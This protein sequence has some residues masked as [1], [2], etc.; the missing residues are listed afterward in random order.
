MVKEELQNVWVYSQPCHLFIFL[1]VYMPSHLIR[2][3][4]ERK[5]TGNLASNC[6]WMA[7]KNRANQSLMVYSKY[8]LISYNLL[9][10]F[11]LNEQYILL[12][13]IDYCSIL[14]VFI[15]YTTAIFWQNRTSS[16]ISTKYN[17]VLKN[18]M[19]IGKNIIV[20]VANAW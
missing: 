2:M 3:S 14:V 10:M 16:E 6:S 17:F 7:N 8:H 19:R 9:F 18:G 5:W 4:Y 1:L 11:V 15:F 12:I 20:Q 13:T